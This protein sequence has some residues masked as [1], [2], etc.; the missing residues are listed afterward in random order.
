MSKSK[1]KK[2]LQSFSREQLIEVILAAYDS[3]SKA[4]EY[5]EFFL[6]PDAD[7][8]MDKAIEAI[9]KA[10]DR[11][12]WGECKGRISHI[13]K[14]VREYGA[15]GVGVEKHA[16]MVLMAFELI[17]EQSN[18]RYLSEPLKKGMLAFAAEYAVMAAKNGFLEEATAKIGRALT[19]LARPRVAFEVNIAVENALSDLKIK[20]I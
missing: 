19:N 7:A 6:N 15:F 1:L 20:I 13:R 12:K 10:L 16:V 9:R 5:F 18:Y 2:E 3:S 17:L 4:K 11:N 14:I 8:L